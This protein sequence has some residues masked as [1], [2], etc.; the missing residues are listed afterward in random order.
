MRVRLL[1]NLLYGFVTGISEFLPVS[2]AAHQR[3]LLSLF[4]VEHAGI[5]D[6]LCHMASLLAVCVACRA[7]I[8]HIRRERHLA[9]IPRRR[10]RREPD[11]TALM[12]FSLVR[13]AFVPVLLFSV[14]HI[15]C[16]GFTENLA[17]IAAL[18]VLNG[19][20]LLLPS[21]LPAANKDVRS[22]SPLDSLFIGA[23]A[24]LGAIP[25]LSRMAGALSVALARG[26]ERK[27]ALN[28]ALLLSIPSLVCLMVL[29]VVALVTFG[30][31][32]S[33]TAILGALVAACGAY[34]GAYIAIFFLRFLSVK[35]GF[36]GFAYYC[37]GAA[38]F[39]FILYMMN[40]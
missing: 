10:R 35:Q 4:G 14:L 28:W 34:G 21:L 24:G 9:K 22:M 27:P 2:A 32:L 3:V 15:V 19:V 20:L 33:G 26:A 39:T 16:R 17:V 29:D 23:V 1:Q 12:E 11:E 37:W 18:L 7:Q 31:G 8:S 13:T 36:S 25:G 40:Y 5:S 6:L 30:L 38:L